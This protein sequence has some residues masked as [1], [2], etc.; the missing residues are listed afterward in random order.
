MERRQHCFIVR[1]WREGGVEKGEWR[2][3][4]DH[5]ASCERRYFSALDVLAALIAERI[6]AN[7]DSKRPHD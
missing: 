2:G 3:C 1:L 6:A 5:V 7:E 4:V